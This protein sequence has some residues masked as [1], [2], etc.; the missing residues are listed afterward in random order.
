M[1]KAKSIL[2]ELNQISV[3]RDRN[4]VTS[5]RG[6]HVITSAI[7]LIEQIELNYD[8]KTAKDLTNRLINSI[9][10]R[11]VKKFSRGI[12]KVIKESQREDHAN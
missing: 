11:D 5:N 2:E 1:P 3:D 6:E 10:G 4:H 7:N 9:R 8:E 12:K